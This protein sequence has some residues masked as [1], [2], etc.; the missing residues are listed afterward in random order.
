M[1]W[2]SWPAFEKWLAAYVDKDVEALAAMLYMI[3][4]DPNIVDDGGR[5]IITDWLLWTGDK[6]Y[7][8][9]TYRK[10]ATE[11]IRRHTTKVS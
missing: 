4:I 11:I 9:D 10:I 5:S 2:N 1:E 8:N 3:Q 6:T 7:T